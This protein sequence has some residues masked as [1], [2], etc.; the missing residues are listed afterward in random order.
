VSED[1]LYLSVITIGE[2]PKAI[3]MLGE[4]EA[5]RA[6]LQSWLDRDVRIRFGDRRLPFDVTVAERWGHL[7]AWP[8]SGD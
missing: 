2:V 6:A 1:L 3:D 7:E 4:A 8:G 5:R